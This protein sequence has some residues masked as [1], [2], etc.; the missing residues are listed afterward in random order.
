MFSSTDLDKRNSN[1]PFV[2]SGSGDES[3]TFVR[4]AHK[5]LFLKDVAIQPSKEEPLRPKSSFSKR[6][7]WMIVAVILLVILCL[8]F[9]V[10]FATSGKKG[11]DQ[12]EWSCESPTCISLASGKSNRCNHV[13]LGC[14]NLCR[15]SCFQIVAFRLNLC[16][17]DIE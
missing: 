5:S 6:E 8:I 11:N 2:N 13:P 7:K 1:V 3:P 16:T 10:L 4:A 17:R 12:R 9:I 15:S 14:S